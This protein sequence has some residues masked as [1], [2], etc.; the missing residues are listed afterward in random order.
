MGEH[1]SVI[2]NHIKGKHT[3]S[4]KCRRGDG[5]YSEMQEPQRKLKEKSL[6]TSG[7]RMHS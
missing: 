4:A 3:E 2:L 5:G 6:P 7:I 1:C